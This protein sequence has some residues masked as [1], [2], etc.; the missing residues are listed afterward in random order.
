MASSIG[1]E[2][3][4]RDIRA[5]F[6]EAFGEGAGERVRVACRDDGGRRLISEITIGLRGRYA[7]RNARIRTLSWPPP[8]PMPGCPGGVV[9]PVGLQ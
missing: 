2:V 4:A 6:D 1:R 9:D 3:T 8:P 5:S 7:G